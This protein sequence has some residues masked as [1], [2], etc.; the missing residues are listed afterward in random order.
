V[1][2]F[3]CRL[4]QVHGVVDRADASD[5]VI[6]GDVRDADAVRK[7]MAGIEVVYHLAAETGVG[8][9]Q[10][11][12]A[13]YVGTNTFG[14]AVVLQEAAAAGVA[15]VVLTSSRAVYGEGSARCPA[16]GDRF[17]SSGRRPRDMDNA[18]WEV[19]CPACGRPADPFPMAETDPPEPTSVY[20]VTK[21]QQEELARCVSATYGIPVTILRLFNVFGPGQSLRNPYVGVLGTFFRRALSGEAVELYEDGH[22]T[23]DFVFVEDVVDVLAAAIDNDALHGATVNVGS[24]ASLELS[25]LAKQL[26]VCLGREPDIMVSG[27]YRV[28]DVRHA[29]ADTGRL[30][31]MLGRLPATELV[32]G[33]VAYIGWALAH[34]ADAVDDPAAAQLASRQLLRRS[35]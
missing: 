8:Q 14:T 7:A 34:P 21:L 15:H 24:G 17:A 23:R 6:D 33:L 28:G 31:A 12:I 20:G 27:R 26:F 4:A 5:G 35:G 22:M 16:C 19:P 9:S 18:I 1:T 11:E 3:D 29:V 30:E 13:R 32:D 10:Y 2:V 25:D